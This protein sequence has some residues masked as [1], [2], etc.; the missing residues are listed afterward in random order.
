MQKND[1]IRKKLLD[2]ATLHFAQKGYAGTN[3]IEVAEEVGVSRGPLYYY[4][5]NKADLYKACVEDLIETKREAYSR[6]LI[7][8]RPILEMIREDYL[9]CL[10]DPGLFAQVG[11]GGKGEPDLSAQVNEF[12]QWLIRRKQEVFSDAKAR[13]ELPPSCDI[14]ELITFIYVYYHGVIYVKKSSG[15]HEGFSRDMLDHSEEM[16]LEI[17]QRRFL[18][19]E[20]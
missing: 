17:I 3:L 6:I 4:F 15:A 10:R 2:R 7:P 14:A 12:S 16:F 8:G 19:P 9:Y 5:A 13:G 1:A 11:A 18:T 20:R